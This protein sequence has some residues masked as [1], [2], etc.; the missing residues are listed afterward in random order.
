MARGQ[1]GAVTARHRRGVDAEDHRHRRL[2][3]RHRRNGHGVFR[4]GDRLA[5]GDVVDAGEADDVAGSRFLDLDAFEPLEGEQ[6]GDLGLFVLAV[7]LADDDRVVQLDPAV[8]DAADG[9]AA[10]VVA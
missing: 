7:Q 8:G 5:D 4:V 6:L 1:V 3:H 9:D 2:V 10:Q